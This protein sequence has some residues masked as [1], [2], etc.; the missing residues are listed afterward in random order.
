MNWDI[1]FTL[2]AGFVRDLLMRVEN[3]DVD[4]VVEGDGFSLQRPFE[5]KVP[6]RIRS[7]KK[8]GTAIHPLPRA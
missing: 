8:F 6:C 7:H 1:R 5:E 4:I 3:F 2:G